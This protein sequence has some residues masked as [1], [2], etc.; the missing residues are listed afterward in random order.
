MQT[1]ASTTIISARSGPQVAI[2]GDGQVSLGETIAKAD[3]VKVRR[4]D[5]VGSDAAGVLVGFA[6]SAAGATDEIGE[7]AV[8]VVHPIRDLHSTILHLLG[9]DDNKLTY[10]HGGRFKQLS[11]I[12]ASVIK[13][14]VA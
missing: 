1:F 10:L 14:I 5:E 6:G 8:S 3:A 9:L 4:L 2:A 11:Q 7:K 12:G 13:E